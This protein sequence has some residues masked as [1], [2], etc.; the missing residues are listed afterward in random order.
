MNVVDSC[1]WLEYFADGANA[2]FFAPVIEKIDELLVPDIVVFEVCRRVLALRGP[3]AVEQAHR[4]MKQGEIVHLNYDALAQAA[5]LSQ[6]HALA[7]GDALIYQAALSRNAQ[8]WTQDAAF[9]GLAS[10]R[11]KAKA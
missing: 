8:L 11:Y 3:E 2:K 5:K 7:M 1:G 10:V 4:Y 9:S 6:A